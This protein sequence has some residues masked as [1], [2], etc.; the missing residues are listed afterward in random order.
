[1]NHFIHVAE[2]LT[3]RNKIINTSHSKGT[4]L[5]VLPAEVYAAL[6]AAFVVC[7][8]P[9][10]DVAV[11]AF[12]PDVDVEGAE[13]TAD[14]DAAAEIELESVNVSLSLTVDSAMRVTMAVSE[15]VPLAI[16]VTPPSTS[17]S[18]DIHLAGI[19]VGDVPT[20]EKVQS[21]LYV[22]ELPVSSSVKISSTERCV[23]SSTTVAAIPR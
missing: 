6:E 18:T 11:A 9:E 7:G 16:R 1:M 17:R 2:V 22:T 13:V 21:S 10:A 5:A 23:A 12:D 3:Y 19:A 15:P 20:D 14:V 4:T 8:A